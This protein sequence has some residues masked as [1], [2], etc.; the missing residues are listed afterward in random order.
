MKVT[1]AISCYKQKKWLYR[2]LR[3][4]ASQTMPKDEFEVI[5]VND[6]PGVMLE[7]VCNNMRDDLTLGLSTTK[8]T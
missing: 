3:S 4:L 1:V 8:K 6:E 5:I 7:D 2:C